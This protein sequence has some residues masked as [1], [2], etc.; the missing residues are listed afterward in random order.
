MIC[1]L[2]RR[3]SLFVGI[4]LLLSFRVISAADTLPM[5][6][7][8]SRAPRLEKFLRS[9]NCP[10]P[11]L[12]SEYLA[13]ADEYDI[14]YRLLPALSVRESTCG[15]HARL[16][17]RWGWNSAQTGFATLAHGIRFIAHEL[18]FGRYYRGKTLDQKLQVYNPV[19]PYPK[20]VRKLMREIE[21]D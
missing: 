14:D 10:A 1:N 8:D 12:T 16:N 9:Y 4:G 6:S 18:A 20:E 11:L 17:N 7:H 2:Q 19:L 21:A 5:H 15:L 13:A 3:T